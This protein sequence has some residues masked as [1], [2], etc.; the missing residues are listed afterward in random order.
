MF[1][2]AAASRIIVNTH[3][4]NYGQMPEIWPGERLPGRRVVC[5]LPAQPP[6]VRIKS[7][8]ITSIRL[9]A[10][11]RAALRPSCR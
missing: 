10:A 6:P 11:W 7:V 2:Q 8:R 9:P 3:R 5:Q 1:R 4:V